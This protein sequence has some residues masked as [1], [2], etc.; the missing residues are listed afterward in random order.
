MLN[1]YF[2]FFFIFF[3]FASVQAELEELVKQEH[4]RIDSESKKEKS[5]ESKGAASVAPETKKEE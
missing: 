3:T 4:A 2:L 5:S 1:P